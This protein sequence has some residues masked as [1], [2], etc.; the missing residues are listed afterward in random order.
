MAAAN[1]FHRTVKEEF[2]AVAFPRTFYESVEPSHRDLKDYLTCY[3]RERAHQGYRT[4]GRT[5]CQAFLDGIEA[6]LREE[7]KP[8]AA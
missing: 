3:K 8:E 1:A 5:P 2:Y 7:V 4:Q 6:M